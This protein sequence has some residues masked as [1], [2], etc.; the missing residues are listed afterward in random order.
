MLVNKSEVSL[1]CEKVY[2]I[3][4]LWLSIRSSRLSAVVFNTDVLYSVLLHG[5]AASSLYICDCFPFTGF[6]LKVVFRSQIPNVLRTCSFNC[7]F[8]GT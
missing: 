2:I 4:L 8:C 7:V 5:T 6:L 3:A 1:Y